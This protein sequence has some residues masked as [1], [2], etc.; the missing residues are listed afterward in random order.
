MSRLNPQS[1]R[2]VPLLH[3]FNPD[4]TSN[5]AFEVEALG[6]GVAQRMERYRANS[7]TLSTEGGA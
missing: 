6:K 7:A 5:V 3:L 1:T 2:T 4:R